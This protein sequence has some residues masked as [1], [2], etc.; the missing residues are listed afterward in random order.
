MNEN[1]L[2]FFGNIGP[3][4]TFY[5]SLQPDPHGLLPKHGLFLIIL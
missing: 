5:K 3:I 2:K 4:L 1:G